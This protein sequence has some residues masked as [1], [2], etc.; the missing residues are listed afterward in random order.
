M[1]AA[2]PELGITVVPLLCSQVNVYPVVFPRPAPLTVTS[3]TVA[4][5]FTGL[6]LLWCE[7][8]MSA[9]TTVMSAGALIIVNV[10][11]VEHPL[12]GVTRSVTRTV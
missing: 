2:L 3:F 7:S 5:P 8:A 10:L 9:L 12:F 11:V 1:V 6:Q 4:D